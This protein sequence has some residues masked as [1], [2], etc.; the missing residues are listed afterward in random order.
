MLGRTFVQ[1]PA[2]TMLGQSAAQSGLAKT[3]NHHSEVLVCV[4]RQPRS[5]SIP[6]R[7]VIL[8]I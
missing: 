6:Q 5:A 8:F 4:I 7:F 3:F 1:V 2:K